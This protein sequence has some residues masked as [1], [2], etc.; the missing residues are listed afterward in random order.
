MDI[1]NGSLIQLFGNASQMAQVRES[2]STTAKEIGRVNENQ[3]YTA[4][5]EKSGWF[6]I[7][8]ENDTKEGWVT[9]TYAKKVTQ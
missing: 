5:E 1:N 9:G 8:F 6:K 4:I 7:K 2:N 3:E